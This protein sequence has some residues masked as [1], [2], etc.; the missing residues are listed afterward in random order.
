MRD[1]SGDRMWVTVTNVK[2]RK[3]I[4]TLDNLRVMI[5]R[6]MPGDKIKFKRGHIIDIWY[7]D[8]ISE[9]PGDGVRDSG[10]LDIEVVH[11]GCNG[12]AEDC[13]SRNPPTSLPPYSQTY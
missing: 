11:G 10:H 5:L 7:D 3:L 8:D 12:H 2:K 9:P 4:A 13:P 6:L 1:G